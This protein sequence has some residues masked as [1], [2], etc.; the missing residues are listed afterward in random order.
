MSV[1]PNLSSCN[2]HPSIPH[3][4]PLNPN[5]Q[6]LI[7]HEYP[8][9]QLSIDI[10]S[11]INEHNNESPPPQNLTHDPS[12]S[13]IRGQFIGC[14]RLPAKPQGLRITGYQANSNFKNK[15]HSFVDDMKSFNI[16]VAIIS[17]LGITTTP[18]SIAQMK[19]T[20]FQIDKS[21]SLLINGDP[22]RSN[23]NRGGNGVAIIARG[24]ITLN[25]Y[26][27]TN[28]PRLVAATIILKTQGPPL[29]ILIAGIY[30]PSGCTSKPH[31]TSIID[32]EARLTTDIRKISDKFEADPSLH[33]MIM[34]GDVNSISAPLIDTIGRPAIHREESIA[35]TL[36]G[37]MLDAIRQFVPTQTIFTRPHGDNSAAYIDRIYYSTKPDTL[38]L[39]AAGID[40]TAQLSDHHV[41]FADF[42]GVSPPPDD[43]FKYKPPQP[44]F[45]SEHFRDC[46]KAALGSNNPDTREEF[47]NTINAAAEPFNERIDLHNLT[48]QNTLTQIDTAAQRDYE[49][50]TTHSTNLQQLRTTAIITSVDEA[51]KF[52]HEAAQTVAKTQGPKPKTTR[53]PRDL[54]FK[55][56]WDD[57]KSLQ[58][59]A[60]QFK[61][62][63]GH[64]SPANFQSFLSKARALALSWD[65]AKTADPSNPLNSRLDNPFM[66]LLTTTLPIT[67]PTNSS[68]LTTWRHNV[69]TWL[70]THFEP[71]LANR[72]PA[73]P[74]PKVIYKTLQ[75]YNTMHIKKLHKIRQAAHTNSCSDFY[76]FIRLLKEGG[77][78][79]AMTPPTG[80]TSAEEAK[81]ALHKKYTSSFGLAETSKVNEIIENKAPSGPNPSTPEWHFKPLSEIPATSLPYLLPALNRK[82]LTFPTK[83]MHGKL[84]IEEKQVFSDSSRSPGPSGI[85]RSVFAYMPKPWRT[86]YLLCLEICVRIAIL[87]NFAKA[88][89]IFLLPKPDGGERPLTLLEDF[90]KCVERVLKHRLNLIRYKTYRTGDLLCPDNVAYEKGCGTSAMLLP[91]QLALA[92]A[93]QEAKTRTAEGKDLPS[94]EQLLSRG[95]KPL[96]LFA[97]DFLKFFDLVQTPIPFALMRHRGINTLTV[98]F[99]EHMYDGMTHQVITPW[100]TTSPIN[101]LRGICQGAI[102]SDIIARFAVDAFYCYLNEHFKS[103]YALGACGP[104][105]PSKAYSDDG[106]AAFPSES[107]LSEWLTDASILAGIIHLGFKPKALQILSNFKLQNQHHITY[108]GIEGH[109]TSSKIPA[110]GPHTTI[111]ILG[112]MTSLNNPIH[113]QTPKYAKSVNWLLRGLNSTSFSPKE[114][115]TAIRAVIIPMMSYCPLSTGLSSSTTHQWDTT[116]TRYLRTALGLPPSTSRSFLFTP[117]SHGGLGA[118]SFA[119]EYNAAIARELLFELHPESPSSSLLTWQWQQI[120]KNTNDLPN[121]NCPLSS[122]IS[123][124]ASCGIYI[125]SSQEIELNTIMDALASVSSPK[126]DQALVLPWTTST[127]TA[128]TNLDRFSSINTLACKLRLALPPYDEDFWPTICRNSFW[129]NKR[130]QHYIGASATSL[131]TAC[132]SARTLINDSWLTEMY[133]LRPYSC[134]LS[135]AQRHHPPP[136][137]PRTPGKQSYK[138]QNSKPTKTIQQTPNRTTTH[139]YTPSSKP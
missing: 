9:E 42:T 27:P 132:T 88:T 70:V 36:D 86:L 135:A 133:L 75:N 114:M 137:K 69:R 118:K 10:S 102:F 22:N 14:Q 37:L 98:M 128:A 45:D 19:T 90:T 80:T 127:S 108:P 79:P 97:W 64:L 83:E 94:E 39:F 34:V 43:A 53:N 15:I 120:T 81:A 113:A 23:K 26:A 116:A 12:A 8:E 95:A 119:V 103:Y 115:L 77:T 138:Q 136:Q 99:L 121:P 85:Q 61:Q 130:D 91:I 33:S 54:Q 93:I 122:A 57:L 5:H 111:K 89:L 82:T 101:R 25:P 55:K 48:L 47:T 134:T 67:Q 125:R 126:H 106:A 139:G 109:I 1:H 100:G 60:N 30:G 71:H 46:A 76:K 92:D 56:L 104:Q 105:I 63:D 96:V 58:K 13:E 110:H 68:Q 117:P 41:T 74:V 40:L 59:T 44:E 52:L 73:L 78:T 131:A 20:L 62:A 66:S 72:T 7:H 4:Y 50:S 17:E 123:R 84:T 11:F 65:N 112:V 107:A 38:N 31:N 24:G 32:Q 6:S 129:H 2:T 124:L 35:S 28:N 18:P 49:Q 29:H 16:D 51:L 3:E 87:P 21:Y